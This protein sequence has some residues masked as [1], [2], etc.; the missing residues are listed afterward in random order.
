MM[1]LNAKR[2]LRFADKKVWKKR[3]QRKKRKEKPERKR[4]GGQCPYET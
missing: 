1:S 4:E 3:A 2:N